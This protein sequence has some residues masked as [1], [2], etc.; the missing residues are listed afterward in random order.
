MILLTGATGMVGA[1]I[2]LEL[3]RSGLP[4]RGLR[5]PN[6]S[7]AVAESVFAHYGEAALFG[8]IEWVTGDV[9]DVQSLEDAM[10][11]VDKVI[12]AAALVSFHPSQRDE[13]WRINGDGTAN[14]VNTALYLGVGRL[15]HISSISALGGNEFGNEIDEDAWWK[16]APGNT[17]YAI[18][19]YNAE[20]EVWRGT[21]EGLEAVIL[22]P[23]Y[24]IGPGD[25]SRS[26]NV[27][28]PIA[29]KGT[30]WFTEG[31]TG[32]VDARDVAAA[33]RWALDCPNI[34]QRF[35]VNAEN[36]TYRSF[37]DYLMQAF[38]HKPVS[39]PLKPWM[40]NLAWRMEKLLSWFG[41]TPKL[42]RETAAVLHKVNRFG[43]Q[44]LAQ[45]MKF[46]Y[47]SVSEAVSNAVPFYQRQF[48]NSAK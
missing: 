10:Q 15:V 20:R 19:K 18:S 23:S 38:G 25:A 24:V 43:G 2:A 34:A 33:A 48:S 4:V 16:N 30:A 6:S 8:K 13:L 1:H 42:T 21:E 11:G 14:V 39:R 35:V 12:H 28:F 32:Y 26:S 29:H 31:I 41:R 7:L 45:T 46:N 47:R 40:T 17:Q 9:L 44:K 22:N 27:I 3:L 37:L 36:I 5:R